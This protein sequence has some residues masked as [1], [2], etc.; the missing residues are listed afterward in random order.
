MGGSAFWSFLVRNKGYCKIDLE[1]L[2]LEQ[3]DISGSVLRGNLISSDFSS[4]NMCRVD[5]RNCNAEKSVWTNCDIKLSYAAKLK[6]NNTKCKACVFNLSDLGKA[7]FIDA[8]IT[9]V[10]FEFI[11][12]CYIEFDDSRITSSNFNRANLQNAEFE[13]S[14]LLEVKFLGA[15][16]K[17]ANFR[18]AKLNKV[19]FSDADLS[20]VDFRGVAFQEVIF[21]GAKMAGAIF[22]KNGIKWLVQSEIEIDPH[23]MIEQRSGHRLV[24]YKEYISMK[25]ARKK[26]PNG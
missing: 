4:C 17:N 8:D 2:H 23:I 7:E 14:T 20:D 26:Q 9:D 21:G 25:K 3:A 6:L 22:D 10:S 11:N 18:N 24:T 15:I 19:D 12:G 16:L 13:N 1:Y 5:F